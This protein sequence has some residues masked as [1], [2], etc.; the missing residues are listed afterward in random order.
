MVRPLWSLAGPALGGLLAAGLLVVPVGP[1]FRTIQG[2]LGLSTASTLL[3]VVAPYLV[4]A[5]VLAVPGLLLGRRWPTLT[6]VPALGFLAVGTLVVSFAPS[7]AV[8]AVGRVIA[9]LG[10]GA[11]V[12]VA[13]ALAGQLDR[14]R[15]QARLALGLALA[16]AVLIGPVVGGVFATLLS[17]RVS[18]LVTVPM[19]GIALLVTAVTGIAMWTRRP[20]AQAADTK[21]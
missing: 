19:A 17:W 14:W 5:L 13:L 21:S 7:T 9:G 10:A 20:S 6:G 18:F 11:V 4:A 8:M 15:S 12:G 1:L 16:A 3:S 2:D